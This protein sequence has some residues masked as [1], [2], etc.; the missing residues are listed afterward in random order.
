MFIHLIAAE[1][2][3]NFFGQAINKHYLVIHQEYT[4]PFTRNANLDKKPGGMFW[5]WFL[6]ADK[7]V[8]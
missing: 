7:K 1:K 8:N 4:H 5:Q 2:K 6:R 3:L